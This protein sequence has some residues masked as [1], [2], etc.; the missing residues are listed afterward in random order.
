MP[1]GTPFPR[2]APLALVALGLAGCIVNPPGW[3]ERQPEPYVLRATIGKPFG[4]YPWSWTLPNTK[5]IEISPDE[6]GLHAFY[7]DAPERRLRCDE[8]VQRPGYPHA[9]LVCWSAWDDGNSIRFWLAPDVDCPWTAF[10]QIGTNANRSC[11]S[12]AAVVGGRSLTFL[13]AHQKGTNYPMDRATWLGD[14]GE[15]VLAADFVTSLKIELYPRARAPEPVDERM[16]LL[17]ASIAYW[18]KTLP[19]KD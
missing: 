18:D 9:R 12:G 15:L 6:T 4:R 8:D 17:V 5:R 1:F 19:F 16:A 11:W 14:D 10:S 2:F 7:T 3:P 13:R